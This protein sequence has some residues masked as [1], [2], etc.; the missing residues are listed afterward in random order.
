LASLSLDSHNYPHIAYVT[1][2]PEA[3]EG[4]GFLAYASWNGIS[5]N[6]QAVNSPDVAGSCFLLLD[7]KGNPHISI[8]G[9][10]PNLPN[11]YEETGAYD[12]TASLIYATIAEPALI[13]SGFELLL[14]VASLAVLAVIVVSLLLYMRKRKPINSSQ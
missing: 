5:W 10:N 6:I 2:A 7:S 14:V 4:F 8:V 11:A 9:I 1:N 13:S 12:Y 3:G